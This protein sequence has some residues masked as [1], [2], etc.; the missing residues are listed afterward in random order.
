MNLAKRLCEK[1]LNKYRP[2]WKERASR[3]K[4][5][6]HL[7]RVIISFIVM[8]FIWYAL[9]YVMWHVH[10]IA[11]PEHTG[12]IGEFW[13]KGISL[14]SFLS[15]FLLVMPLFLPALG[16]SFI[17]VNIIFWFIPPAKKLFENEAGGEIEMTFIGTTSDLVRVVVKYM[18]PIGLGLS[19]LGALTLSNLK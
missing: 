14:K 8:G 4:S 16:L 1:V 11:Y 7:P 15:S 3:R 19:L 18:L 17:I 6:W 2:G 9:F 12:Q 5:L 13:N 10:L